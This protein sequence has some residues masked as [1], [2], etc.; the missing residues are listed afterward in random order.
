M[1]LNLNL[2]ILKDVKG[3]LIDLVKHGK[4]LYDH[5]SWSREKILTYSE[6]KFR[7]LLKYAYNN[8]PFYKKLYSASGIEFG[9]LSSNEISQIPL[10]TKKD[11][12]NNFFEITSSKITQSELN[13]LANT[14]SMLPQIKNNYIVHT[15][16]TTGVPAT[17]LYNKKAL[18][19]LEAHFARLSINGGER[20]LGL[21]DFPIKSLYIAPVGSGYASTALATFGLEQ[22][23][24][25]S[26]IINA[27]SPLEKWVSTVGH[28]NPTYLSGY[29]SCINISAKLNE[30]GK[31]NISPKKIITGG[32]PLTKEA[33]DYF[34]K[35]FHAD[36]IDYYGCTE[37]IFI[38]AGTSFYDGLYLYDDLNYTEVDD[39]NR[40]II[41]PLYNSAFPLIRY[42]L[43]DIM[44]GFTKE[45]S[46]TLPYTHINK[47]I[48]REEELM[49]FSNPHG[50]M[51][52]LHP[53]FL[54]DLNVK[55]ITSYQFI[56][57]SLN[58][59]KL[60]CITA[61]PANK[62]SQLAEIQKQISQFLK[63]KNLENLNYTV[64][65]TNQLEKNEKTG[66]V[67]MVIKDF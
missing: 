41:T 42:K 4:S 66:K 8:C 12:I 7:F 38:G 60:K 37:S 18:T 43:S 36:I 57:K 13:S 64:E 20:S 17:F 33:C 9:D 35:V 10:I 16:G 32:E 14:K 23:K 46:G 63:N 56:Q 52:F 26:I 62:D 34:K 54:D 39:I 22:Y 3:M 49:W 30:E 58:L 19:I 53:M 6:E 11:I 21:K 65:F 15:S 2:T 40:L 61:D 25:K 24:C 28:Y 31:I 48:G 47:V 59:F 27:Q 29:P 51:D 67:K 55:G 1:F 44:D 45:Q 50:K 5:N